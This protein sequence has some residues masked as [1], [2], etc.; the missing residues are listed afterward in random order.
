MENVRKKRKKM[1]KEGNMED[2]KE[3]GR[4]IERRTIGIT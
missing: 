1:E 4:E 3:K 2:D